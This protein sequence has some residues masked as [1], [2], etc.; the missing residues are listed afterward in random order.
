MTNTQIRTSFSVKRV[1]RRL[2]LSVLLIG[3][4]VE[5]ALNKPPANN[6]PADHSEHS[7]P[8]TDLFVE[9]AGFYGPI[10]IFRARPSSGFYKDGIYTGSE[11]VGFY[12]NVQ[13]QA[14]IKGG[15]IVSVRFLEYPQ[16]RITSIH[17]NQE[18]RP[19]LE[20]EA[21]QAQTAQVDVVTGATLTSQ[22][23]KASLQNALDRAGRGL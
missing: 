4:F 23:F 3:A 12:G 2:A 6:L 10:A 13:V 8:P 11:V 9:E 15:K 7:P 17:I 14:V 20:K 16:Y 18:A 1:I 21:I 19:I 22:G 5:Y